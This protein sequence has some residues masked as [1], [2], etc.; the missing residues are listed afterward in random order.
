MPYNPLLPANLTPTSSAELRGQL[1]GLFDLIQAMPTQPITSFVVD[2]TNTLNPGE[3][4]SATVAVEAPVAHLTFNIPRGSVGPEGPPFMNYVVD[5]VNTLPAGD[6][7]MVALTFDGSVGHFAF[8]IP[9]G[10][11]GAP[12]EVSSA[13]MNIAISSA[14]AGTAQNPGGVGALGL[15]I[16]DPPT[17]AEMQAL[18]AHVEELRAAL[19]RV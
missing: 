14:I 17:Q 6:N 11:P 15:T 13:A 19:Q 9:R 10:D 1:T 2:A 18:A 16:S 7:A 12:G 4:A 3:N 5:F 8:H